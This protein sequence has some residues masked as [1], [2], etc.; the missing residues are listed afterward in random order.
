[1]TGSF[2]S[3]ATFW[4][5]Y[6]ASKAATAHLASPDDELQQGARHAI[7]GATADVAS[8]VIRNPFEV[9][10]PRA[11]AVVVRGDQLPCVHCRS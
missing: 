8:A 2:P 4:G 1:M 7:C 5:T 11:W 6:E 3:A 10:L 9:R